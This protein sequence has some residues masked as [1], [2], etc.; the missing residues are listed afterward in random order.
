MNQTQ[1]IGKATIMLFT[2]LCVAGT[3][4]AGDE[5][6]DWWG[7]GS[8]PENMITVTWVYSSDNQ[9]PNTEGIRVGYGY[10][11]RAKNDYP[12]GEFWL[13]CREGGGREV[14]A[15][16]LS[17]THVAFQ[18]GRF[19]LGPVLDL[20]V[21]VHRDSGRSVFSGLIGAGVDGVFRISPRWDLVATGEAI[22]RTT[23]EVEYQGRFG[24]RFHR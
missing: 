11:G 19:G 4:L 18:K 13:S 15:A 23:S 3:V 9:G 6:V 17:V 7:E 22:Y 24:A 20:G 14:T 5:P 16:G 10:F 1:W 12:W 2:G 8:D 21:M